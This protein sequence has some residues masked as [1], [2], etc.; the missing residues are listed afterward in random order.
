M[1]PFSDVI[2]LLRPHTALSKPISGRGHWGVRYA[3]YGQP[4][5]ALVLAGQV[6]LALD[7]A[8]PVLL[9]RGDFLLL[10]ATPAFAMFS[11]PGVECVPV[12]PTDKP[13][14]H[15]DPDGEPDLQMLGGAFQI[16]SANA[17][18]LT[19]LLPRMIHVRATESD[20]GRLARVIHL[21]R[22]ECVADW[23]GREMILQRLLEVML[24]EC[25]RR[26][27][28]DREV[29]SAGLLAGLRD[30]ALAGALRAMHADVRAGWTVAG[31]ARLAGMS[32]SAF[33]A[34]FSNALGC[35][36]MEY[37]SRWRMSLAQDA[38]SRGAKPL[39]R[40]AEEI[41]YES[42]SAF[43]TAFRRRIGCSPGVFA[44]EHRNAAQSISLPLGSKNGY[45]P[46]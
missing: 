45:G 8:E 26:P 30:Q 39:D 16:E 37:L 6:W 23:P 3:A 20:T 21:L 17:S 29:L 13:V 5:F 15:G 28:I 31:L 9:E 2:A 32:R 41:G 27:G 43:S 18:L 22:E 12:E 36:P 1:D 38:L 14:R 10:P 40:L 44:R 34:R 25:L 33:A 19:A 4:G 7:E 35:A 11:H 42:A 24:V 46:A